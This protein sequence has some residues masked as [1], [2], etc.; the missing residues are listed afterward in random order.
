MAD[1]ARTDLNEFLGAKS[2]PAW[3]RW[4]KWAA[5]GVGILL[6]LILLKSCFGGTAKPEYATDT[7]ARGALAVSVSATGKLAP[8]NQVNVGSELSGLVTKVVVDVNDRVTKGQPLAL[9]DPS[10]FQDTVNQSQAALDAAVAT[11][12]QNQATLSQSNAT[13]ARFQEVSRLSGGRVP[14]KTEMD[15][16]IADRNRA[17]ANVRAAQANVASARATLSSN[18][19]QLVKTV[20]RSPV[21]GVVLARQIEPGQTVAASF[22]TPTL[23]VIAEDLSRMKLQVAIDEAD[24]GSVKEGQS[25]V[26]TVDAFPGKTFPAAITRVDLGSNLS[27]QAST[28]TTTTTTT[29]QVVSYSATLSVG[30]ANLQLRP[31]M[32]G[33]ADIT[34]TAKTN[35]LLVPNAALRFK[36][37]DTGA[38]ANKGIAGALMPGRPRRGGAGTGKGETVKRGGSQTVYIADAQ[39]TPQPVQITTGESNGAMTE[40]I[41]GNLKP[42]DKVITGQLAAGAS[43]SGA[44]K[45]KRSGGQAGGQ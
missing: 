42:G 43:A 9:V 30:N 20:I 37:T 38:S 24:V 3:R 2:V 40:V 25:A 45:R 15:Q 1:P 12:A 6:L 18:A 14:A 39:G 17:I 31:G 29:G 26:F 8:T 44:G 28:T 35:V 11:V 34:T 23:F 19:T 41:G 33:T 7:V 32:T 22:S 5:V 21:N 16:A 13:L 36:P 10:R 4:A 27:A